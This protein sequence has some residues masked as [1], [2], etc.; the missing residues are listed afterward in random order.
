MSL[1]VL[2]FL[3]AASSGDPTLAEVERAFST[4]RADRPLAARRA[5]ASLEK[6]T[7]AFDDLDTADN[8]LQRAFRSDVRKPWR[9]LPHERVLTLTTLAA[10]DVGA[11]HCDLALPTLKNAAFHDLRLEVAKARTDTDAVVVHAL[12]LHCL[13]T[14]KASAGDIA[15]AEAAFDDALA[16]QQPT[17]PTPTTPAATTSTAKATTRAD[18]EAVLAGKNPRLVYVGTAPKLAR[19][20]AQGEVV[21]FT[22]VADDAVAFV[23]PLTAGGRKPRGDQE[24]KAWAAI[25][26]GIEVWSS[27]TQATTAQG[28]D[29]KALLAQRATQKQAIDS[30]ANSS[31]NR[32]LSSATSANSPGGAAVGAGLVI[33]GLGMKAVGSS[34]DARADTRQIQALPDRIYLVADP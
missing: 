28:R 16:L 14:Q 31:I 26:R 34:V 27:S 9:G 18:I 1:A 10:L 15:A 11:G 12:L 19:S 13:R 6:A 33:A 4:L 23:V 30:S 25:D 2:A 3:V 29:I 20:G 22:A 5:R 17:T 8:D 7:P 21:S 24:H 32:G